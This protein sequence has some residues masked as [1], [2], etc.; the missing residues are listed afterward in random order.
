MNR[1]S[2]RQ[3][4]DP[5]LL[6]CL[7]LTLFLA[8]PLMQDPGL[9]AALMVCFSLSSGGMYLFCKRRSGRLGA[10]IAGLV[11]VYSP[12]LMHDAPY[13]RGAFGELLALALFP[14]LLWR[15]DALRDKPEPFSLLLVCLL[16]A[17]MLS[18]GSATALALTG[19]ACAWLG[20]ETLIQRFNREA[21]QMRA[22]SGAL[23]GLAMLLGI[24]GVAALWQPIWPAGESAAPELSPRFLTLEDLLSAPPIQDAGALNAR[25]ELP[26]LGLAQWALAALGALAALRL[27]IGGYRTR[28]PNAFLGT[29]VFSALA[30]LLVFLMQPAATGFWNG[31]PLKVLGA[32]ARLLGPAAACLAIMASMN[33]LWLDRLNSRYKIS[34]IAIIVALPIVT[35]IPLLYAPEWRT[36]P[37]IIFGQSETAGQISGLA[38][39]L[40]LLLA[41]V[42]VWR[43]RDRQLTPRPYWSTPALSRSSMIGVLL[44]GAVALLS[45]LI[46]FR[47]GIAWIKSP[48]GQALPAQVQRPSA[49]DEN[50]QLL[51]YDL[52][53]DVFRPGDRL[54]FTAYWY[55]LERPTANYASFLRLSTDEESLLLAQKPHAAGRPTSDWWG[56]DGYAAD[57]Y[58]ARLPADLAAGDYNVIIE[59]AVCDDIWLVDCAAFD[60]AGAAHGAVAVATIRVE[61]P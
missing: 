12:Y 39:G 4:V 29:A 22:S 38:A 53:A 41:V 61:A 45:L 36:A 26:I 2:F 51:G 5:G 6:L 28:H 56:P 10:L 42:I 35:T 24:F 54:T 60:A 18:T 59:L 55:A 31:S 46:T 27:Y 52:N 11:Y 48:P 17:L 19:S 15:L 30:L 14:L 16:Q 44:G 47:E 49:L 25:S 8:L 3:A 57:H 50:I 21:S 9:P 23:A 32:P 43:L 20:A 33:G 37:E 1:S 58:Q 13:V 7:L 40:A 34:L